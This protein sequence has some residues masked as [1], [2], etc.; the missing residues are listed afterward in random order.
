MDIRPV[1]ANVAV[2]PQIQP[3]DMAELAKQGFVAVICN[4][5]DGEEPGQPDVATMR[6]AAEA[7]GLAYHH[8]PISSGQFTRP[9]VEAY[10]AV[11]RG[12]PGKVL[13]YC[14]SGT[15]CATLE[16]LANPDGLPLAERISNAAKAG[17]DLSPLAA[18]LED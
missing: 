4:R 15:R 12:T 17:Y 5:P 16:T 3:E 2:A 7:A 1:S 8:I 18:Q 14:R 11:R 6:A 9:A 10:A 13:A